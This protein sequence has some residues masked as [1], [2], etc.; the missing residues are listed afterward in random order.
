MK[1]L[2]VAL[3]AICLSGMSAFAETSSIAADFEQLRKEEV[4]QMIDISEKHK[5]SVVDVEIVWQ[6][7]IE[8]QGQNQEQENK[9]TAKGVYVRKDGLLVVPLALIDPTE[10]GLSGVP[11]EL[12]S[13]IKVTANAQ[14][15]KIRTQDGKEIEAEILLKDTEIGVLYVR[16]KEKTECKNFLDLS[17]STEAK[18]MNSYYAFQVMEQRYGCAVR[19]AGGMFNAQLTKPRS[20]FLM[21]SPVIGMPV[22]ETKTG[23]IYGFC[24]APKSLGSFCLIT[25]EE[26]LESISQVDEE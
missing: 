14:S 2:S 12:R 10:A 11:V 1:F 6:I 23:K 15:T 26:L 20:C 18:L 22:F 8:F 7:A 21:N 3:A 16:A 25:C 17:N 24:L 5:S 19:H 4:K 9:A 13:Q